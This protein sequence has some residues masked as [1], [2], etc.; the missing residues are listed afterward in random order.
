VACFS[1]A[2][3]TPFARVSDTALGALAEIAAGDFS[4]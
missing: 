3:V 4:Q 2:K 1:R